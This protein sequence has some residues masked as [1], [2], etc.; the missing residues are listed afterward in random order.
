MKAIVAAVSLNNV[1]GRKN[2]YFDQ[3]LL[4]NVKDDL[5][6]FKNLTLHSTVV[7]GKTTY[8]TIGRPLKNRQ[9]LILSSRPFLVPAYSSSCWVY[10]D[11]SF[12]LS[13]HKDEDLFFIG[14]AKVFAQV[15][16]IVD[17]L[18]ISRIEANILGDVFFPDFDSFNV[19]AI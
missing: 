9:N 5:R 14:G 17:V 6:I 11:L 15:L 8:K 3:G 10:S 13:K 2:F 7:M 16:P 18:F 12:L 19:A 1:I 4:W